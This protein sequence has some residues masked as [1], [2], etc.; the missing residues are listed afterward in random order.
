MS[1]GWVLSLCQVTS[2]RGWGGGGGGTSS[3]S[4]VDVVRSLGST[5]GWRPCDSS[6]VGLAH[7][8]FAPLFRI[9]YIFS[10][11]HHELP[12]GASLWEAFF[13]DVLHREPHPLLALASYGAIERFLFCPPHPSIWMESQ[14]FYL[15]MNSDSRWLLRW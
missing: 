3:V 7:H 5:E 9:F 15:L 13:C 11:V 2:V 1:W 8:L 12:K 10:L 14:R 6:G 4:N